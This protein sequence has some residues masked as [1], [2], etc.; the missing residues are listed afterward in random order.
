MIYHLWSGLCFMWWH[1]MNYWYLLGHYCHLYDKI[2]QNQVFWR[3]FCFYA[4]IWKCPMLTESQQLTCWNW[5]SKEAK[6]IEKQTIVN[7]NKVDWAG[8]WTKPGLIDTIW[9][10]SIQKGNCNSNMFCKFQHHSMQIFFKMANFLFSKNW[11]GCINPP[12]PLTLT[13]LPYPRVRWYP[14]F[15]FLMKMTAKDVKE[16]T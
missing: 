1:V 9:E 10:W 4:D 6:S 12:H 3:S 15:L 8:C 16:I 2:R 14:Q 5:W 7:K 13:G 11:K